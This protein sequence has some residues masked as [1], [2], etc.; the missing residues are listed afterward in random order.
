[1][2]KSGM[3]HQMD[4]LKEAHGSD[5]EIE[6]QS[7]KVDK[8][9]QEKDREI[10]ELY[11]DIYQYKLDKKCF[12][13]E[14]VLIEKNSILSIL[15]ILNE[16][17]LDSRD[18]NAD[19]MGVLEHSNF[20]DKQLELITGKDFNSAIEA[21]VELNGEDIVNDV[22]EAFLKRWKLLIE[23]KKEHIKDEEK[24]I[25]VLGLKPYYAQRVYKRYHGL[26]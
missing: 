19:L 22:K 14:L 10:A 18:Y 12:E 2:L 24:D 1:M 20:N 21:L 16:H 15:S 3:Q 26:E 6:D 25:K 11:E 8:S 4:T 23:I 17:K 9:G 5:I 13:D 7:K